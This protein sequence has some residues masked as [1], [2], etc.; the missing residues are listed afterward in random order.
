MKLQHYT[1]LYFAGLLLVIITIWSALFYYAMLDEIYD[2]IDD[3]LDNQKNLII[4]K[5][6]IDT[7]VLNRSEFGE[8]GYAI[9]EIPAT[10]ALKFHDIYTDSMMYMQ[11][12][13]SDEPV[14]ILTSVFLQ[15]NRYYQLQIATSMVEEDDLVRELL[16]SVLWLYIGL[17]ITLVLFNG[18]L[19][20]R[21]WKPFYR[22]LRQLKDFRLDKPRPPELSSTKIE[23]FKLLHETTSRMLRQ[24]I[25]TYRNQKQ[26][27]ENA[28]HELQTP[29]AVAITKLETLAEQAGFDDSSGKLLEDALDQLERLTRLNKSLLLLTKIDNQ[30]FH[31]KKEINLNEIIKKVT[32]DF[33]EFALHAEINVTIQEKAVVRLT[34]NED[35]ALIL[36]T[37]LIKN[38]IIHNHHGGF[39][40]VL[41]DETALT[42]KNSGKITDLDP[43][44]IFNRFQRNK[45]NSSSTGLGLTIAQSICKLY[46]LHISYYFKEYHHIV[47]KVPS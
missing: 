36:V 45:N 12:E 23:E 40:N 34:M 25:E 38:A 21:I 5:A 27:I 46:G 42:I 7:S 2:S 20:R 18:F 9:H 16:K 6:A 24:N 14:R 19:I 43:E 10:G 4:Q 22:L 11:N 1:S 35:L 39:V 37:N 15:N 33:N 28:S 41:I 26:F 44:K 13:Q 8:S 30:Q 29:L 17:I 31:D 32:D 3:G 47:V